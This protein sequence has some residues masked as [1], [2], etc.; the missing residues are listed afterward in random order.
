MIKK[1]IHGVLL[2]SHVKYPIS[3]VAKYEDSVCQCLFVKFETL[4]MAGCVFIVHLT[5]IETSFWGAW[6]LSVIEL[7]YDWMT[8][9]RCVLR[10][11]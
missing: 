2:Y 5:Q 7:A 6:H 9:S 4:K 11:I 8:C 1:F 3:E 10:E